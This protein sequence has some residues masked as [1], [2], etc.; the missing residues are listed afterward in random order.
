MKAKSTISATILAGAMLS[1]PAAAETISVTVTIPKL[2]VAEYHKPYV[3]IWLEQEGVAKPRTLAVWYDHDMKANE[4]NKWLRDLRSW[5][6]VIGRTLS[7]PAKGIS[8]PTRAPGPQ[9]QSFTVGKLPAGN[10]SIVVETSREVGGRE[11]VRMPFKWAAKGS[12]TV[13]G[14]G[15]SE[16]GAV[17]ATIKR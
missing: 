16:L 17:S 13:R 1:A 6:R 5:W 15:K 3:A 14:K 8:G 9:T 7:M 10:Y 2:K 4:G 11:V 12:A